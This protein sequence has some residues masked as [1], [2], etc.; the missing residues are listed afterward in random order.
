M[1]DTRHGGEN[2]AKI[3]QFRRHL[4]VEGA[5]EGVV[6]MEPGDRRRVGY[7]NILLIARD[8]RTLNFHSTRAGRDAFS[9]YQALVSVTQSLRRLSL[10]NF[11]DRN[12][13]SNISA[14]GLAILVHSITLMTQ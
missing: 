10:F 5:I 7:L 4:A 11:R 12:L 1:G 2:G 3:K 13:R 8:P 6:G 9:R 14:K